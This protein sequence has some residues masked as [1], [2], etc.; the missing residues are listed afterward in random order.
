MK[1]FVNGLS[2]LLGGGQT[3]LI[4]L[5]QEVPLA[6]IHLALPE[7]LRQVVPTHP[8]V[9]LV[10]TDFAQKS[11]LHRLLWENFYL[12]RYLRA[13]GIDVYYQPSGTLPWRRLRG[14][15]VAIA[16]RNMLPFAPQE[17]QRFNLGWRRL[18]Y[19]LL[20]QFLGR[21]FV[22][23]DL[24]IFIS[25]YAK[26]VIDQALPQRSGR[27]QVIYHGLAADFRNPT[28]R[29]EPLS[30][31]YVLYVSILNF[32]KAQVEVVRSWALL[33]K[34]RPHTREKL[35]LVGPEIR[36]YGDLVRKE[37]A[38]LGLE[39]EV[40]LMP[41]VAYTALAG[42]YQH[43]KINLF[44]SSCENCP[45]IL[46]EQLA[47][48]RAILSSNFE[49]MPEIAGSGAL[50]FDPYNPEDLCRLILN[51]ID[52]PQ[53]LAKMGTEAQTRSRNFSWQKSRHET[54]SALLGL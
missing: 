40:I 24:V 46:L 41:K 23:A 21:A 38:N 48:G 45:N 34:A 13:Q 29:P 50:Y 20:R 51:T 32:Y 39:G 8:N 44:A 12:P 52:D 28:A 49:P 25:H 22:R 15:R 10:P 43:A 47:A 11:S 16:F 18:R 1:I 54:W 14:Q 7:S 36:R 3:Y 26:R 33:R 17:S 5:F 37:I 4:H 6:E 53:K 31:E 2:A 35:V 42:F 30:G 19:W 27:S 9:R